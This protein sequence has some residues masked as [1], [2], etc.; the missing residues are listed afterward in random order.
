MKHFIVTIKHVEYSSARILVEAE[1]EAR[2]KKVVEDEW[3]NGDWLYEK[4]TDCF[5]NNATEFNVEGAVA[6][7]D[8]ARERAR[9]YELCDLE[10]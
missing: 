1:N 7:E 4:T 2:A 9:C 10:P 8:L 6:R 3:E 5:D